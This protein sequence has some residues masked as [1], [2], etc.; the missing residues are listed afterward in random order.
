V[1]TGRGVK[2]RCCFSAILFNLYSKYFIKETVERFV[3]LKK[4][5]KQFRNVKY[6]VDVVLLVVEE[7][8]LQAMTEGL[9][10]IGRCMEWK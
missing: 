4:E 5:D 9:I 7:S 1:K 8:V 6:A 10:E 3:C 2:Q